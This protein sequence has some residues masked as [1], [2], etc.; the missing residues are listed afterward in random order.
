MTDKDRTDDETKPR[1][2]PANIAPDAVKDPSE[3][4]G[5]KPGMGPQGDRK[6]GGEADPGGG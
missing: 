3:K 5:G 1:K 4:T 2:K 6:P